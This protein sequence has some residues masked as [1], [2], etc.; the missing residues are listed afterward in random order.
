MKVA[1]AFWGLT[2]NLNKTLESI[3]NKILDVFIKNNIEYIIFMH[4][5]SLNRQF[6]NK[7]TGE[8]NCIIDNSEYLYLKPQY[9]IID[10]Q[11]TVEKQLNLQKYRTHVDPWKTNYNSVDNFIIAMYS[12]FKLT[13]LIEISEQTFDYVIFLRPD[14][15]YIN[16]FNLDWFSLVDEKTILVP[17]FHVF[18]NINDRFSI[19]TLANSLQIGKIFEIMYEYSLKKPLHSETVLYYYVTEIL[20]LKV[21]FIPFLFNRVRANGFEQRDAGSPL[22]IVRSP[23][24]PS[25]SSPL[26]TNRRTPRNIVTGSPSKP[27]DDRKL[28]LYNPSNIKTENKSPSKLVETV[29]LEI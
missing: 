27:L 5:Y 14:M 20:K 25:T 17:N 12:K 11:E 7:R 9:S 19:S 16:N 18:A 10:N 23:T 26:A 13:K 21:V 28:E 4:T 24:K 3:Q 1:L 15:R 22:R 2:R 8:T 6:T 29:T